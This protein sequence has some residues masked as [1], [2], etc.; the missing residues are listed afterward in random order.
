ML[1][2]RELQWQF[3]VGGISWRWW[4]HSV[5]YVRVHVSLHVQIWDLETGRPL[6]MR[7]NEHYTTSCMMNNGEHLLMA[8]TDRFG[9]S[10]TLVIWDVLGNE[11][12][13]Q[14]RHD[15]SVGLADHVSFLAIS[16]DD[17][18]AV[19]GAQTTHDGSAHYVVFDLTTVAPDQPRLVAFDAVVDVTVT[20][21]RHEVVTGTRAGQ[22]TIWSLRS[23]KPVRRLA[24]THTAA[25]TDLVLSKDRQMLV[26][27]SA[28]CTVKLWNLESEQLIRTLH[29]HTD[30]VCGLYSSIRR[31]C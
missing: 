28:D 13:R 22:L 18:F 19:A 6:E 8:R 31:I 14:L 4:L 26:S 27:A 17:R 12:L 29:G 23:G 25:V 16:P 20:V 21:D 5:A 30:E 3:I 24:A 15:A 2:H 7:I 9:G 11:R 1:E 10:T